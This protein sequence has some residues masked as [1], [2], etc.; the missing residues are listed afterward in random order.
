MTYIFNGPNTFFSFIE[1]KEKKVF[2]LFDV[3]GDGYITQS[4]LGNVLRCLGYNPT[5][6]EVEEILKE[7]DLDSKN[8]NFNFRKKN[9]AKDWVF[10]S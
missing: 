6:A 7:Y 4:E 9:V 3:N 5:C 2:D 1:L 8:L 10:M